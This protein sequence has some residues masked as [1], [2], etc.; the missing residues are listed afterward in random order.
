MSTPTVSDIQNWLI[1]K[2]AS[3]LEIDR[4]E[5]NPDNPIA[6]FGIDSITMVKFTA[7]LEKWLDTVLDPSL[8]YEAETVAGIAKHI[9]GQLNN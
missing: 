8:L 4:N 6:A 2:I 9:H 7:D 5:I 1:N 3:E